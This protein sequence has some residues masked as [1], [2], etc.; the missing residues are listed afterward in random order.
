MHS[1][2]PLCFMVTGQLGITISLRRSLSTRPIAYKDGGVVHDQIYD[3]IWH[4][5]KSLIGGNILMSILIDIS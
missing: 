1:H 2:L 3:M 5:P 4:N